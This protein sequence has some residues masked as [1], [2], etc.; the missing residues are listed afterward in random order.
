MALEFFTGLLLYALFA[1]Q[2]F[3]N[4]RGGVVEDRPKF[5]IPAAAVFALVPIFLVAL[6]LTR[7]VEQMPYLFMILRY[8]LIVLV[9]VWFVQNFSQIKSLLQKQG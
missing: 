3:I 8:I 2:Y 4:K 1:A 9:V 6:V 5:Y 7:N